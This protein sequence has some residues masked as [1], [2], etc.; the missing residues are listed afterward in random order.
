MVINIIVHI[1]IYL[2]L[3]IK[4]FYVL[5]IMNIVI[6]FVVHHLNNN[7]NTTINKINNKFL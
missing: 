5:K 1:L 7:D 2:I 3:K 4:M 6:M